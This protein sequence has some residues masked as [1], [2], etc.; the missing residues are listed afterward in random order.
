VPWDV[1]GMWGWQ[2]VILQKKGREGDSLQ[3]SL[4][5]PLCLKPHKKPGD[6]SLRNT[7]I[8]S[9]SIA[10]LIASTSNMIH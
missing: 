1:T 9:L 7:V 3:L 6:T 4:G 10:L 2:A 8:L 5:F